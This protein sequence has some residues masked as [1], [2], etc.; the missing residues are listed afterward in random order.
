MTNPNA[1]Y[2]VKKPFNTT[3]QRWVAGAPVSPGDDLSPHNFDDFVKRGFIEEV[4]PVASGQKKQQDVGSGA[5][6][7]PAKVTAP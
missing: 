5:T 6:A 4:K 3:S 7:D 1:T 2:A